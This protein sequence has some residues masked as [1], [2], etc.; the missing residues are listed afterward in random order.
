MPR[1][2][3]KA[4]R[5]FWDDAAV[6]NAMYY[7]DTSLGYDSPDPEAFLAG[8][9]R[10]AEIALSEAESRLPGRTAAIEIGCGLGRICAALA[11]SFDHVVGFDISQEM[12]RRAR[13]LVPDPSVEF[14]H[15]DGLTLPG[16]DD[17][18][19]DL[20]VTFTV[21]QHAPNR[22]VIRANIAEAARVLRDGGVLAVQWNATPN[23]LRWR[24]H[25]LKMRVLAP[26]GRA[27]RHGRDAP[28]FLGTR[29]P[30]R[31]MDRM[32]EAAGLQRYALAEPDSLYTWAWAVR[33]R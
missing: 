10:I 30:Q 14:R 26:L 32:L 27:D 21:F 29:V 25:R 17:A 5:A 33:T 9:R 2:T 12:V 28:Q 20:V 24:L 16:I 4:M 18:S 6:R 7:V 19:V 15:S 11:A 13:G 23:P 22:S 8:G 3:T 31:A 1:R